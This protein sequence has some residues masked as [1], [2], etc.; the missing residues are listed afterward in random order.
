MKNNKGAT[1]IE[2]LIYIG[3]IS[4]ITSSLMGF[5][6]SLSKIRSKNYS[7][8]EVQGNLRT[9]LVFMAKKIMTADEI[10]IA[11]SVFDVD[12]G[13]LSFSKDGTNYL[14]NLNNDDGRIQFQE[15]SNPPVFVTSH[16]VKVSNLV[17]SNL[18]SSGSKS[19]I[20]IEITIEYADPESKEFEYSQSLKT[21]INLRN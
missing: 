9:A 17:F 20:G 13:E 5:I 7:A 6:I 11:S 10:N 14:I 18:T 15:G 2:F 19:S 4:L 1:L 3:V 16:Q 12:P 8:Q 21:A